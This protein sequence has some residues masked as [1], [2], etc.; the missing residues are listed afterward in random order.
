MSAGQAATK[1]LLQRAD[2]LRERLGTTVH[3]RVTASAYAEAA[4]TANAAVSHTG[5]PRFAW[6]DRLDRVVTSRWVGIPFMILL[7]AGVFYMTINGANI[8]SALLAGLLIEEGGLA[9]WLETYLGV[10]QTPWILSH[11][12]YDVLHAAFAWAPAFLTGFLIDGVWLG[13]G[14]VIAVM[15]PPMAIFFPL[16]TLMEDLGLLP[17][18]AFNMD[19]FFRAAGAHGKQALTM[20]MGFG[21]NA[22]GVV[23][24]RIIDSPRER[25][26]AI[27]TNNFV[28]CN[29]RWPTLIMVS[30]LFVAANFSPGWASLVSVGAI[31][32]VTLLGIGM[33]L[34]VSFF[35]SRTML[36]GVAS[37][38][39]LELPPYRKPQLGKIVYRS[40]IDR[41]LFVLWRAML[42]AAPAGGLIW[43]LGAIQVGDSSLF[44]YLSGALDPIGHAIGLDGVILIAYIFA[45]PANEIVVPTIIMGYLNTTRMVE[46]E[47][48]AQLFVEN[49]WTMTTAVCLLLFCLLHNPCTTTTM[50]IYKETG[51]V[52]WTVLS[53]LIPLTVAVACCGIAA[54]V[55]RGM[56]I[57]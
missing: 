38:F 45:I 34:A 9:G 16:F 36:K 31:T 19:R 48:P 52:K 17:R 8:P 12:V 7:L 51:S 1:E 3:D 21:C 53:N 39:Q 47:N 46:L 30:S 4:R 33:T 24:C 50:T 42:C 20:A 25:L 54:A 43:L 14:W 5:A 11:S 28:P 10:Q 32:G 22:A 26:I 35:L 27:L 44:A 55:M 49:G 2:A 13:L 40:L 6:E 23:A 18:I 29:G 37:S 56:G 57:G 41:T 15:L